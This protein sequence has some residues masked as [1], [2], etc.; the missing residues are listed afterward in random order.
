V[1]AQSA[2][3]TFWCDEGGPR[4]YVTFNRLADNLFQQKEQNMASSTFRK[5]DQKTQDRLNKAEQAG[6]DALDKAKE[7]VG[8]AGEAVGQAADAGAAAVGSGMKS[9]AGTVRDQGPHEGMLGRATSTVA[10][11]LEQGGRYLQQEGITG[12]AEDFTELIKR[13][14]IP[15]VLVGIGIG[16]MLAQITRRIV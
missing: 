5:E 12:M 9:L 13:N 3:T 2:G 10:G 1:P 4:A 8:S 15:A 11:G 7:A 14:P 16:F 6:T